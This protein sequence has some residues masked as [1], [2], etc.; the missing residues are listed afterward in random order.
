MSAFRGDSGRT[1]YECVDISLEGIPG[2]IAD[3]DGAKLYHIEASCNGMP[4]PPYN[5][6]KELSCVVCT[7]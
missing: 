1:M 5:S 2:S 3:T 7:R 4:C 6:Y